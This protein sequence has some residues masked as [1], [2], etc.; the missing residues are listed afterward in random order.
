MESNNGQT[1][2]KITCLWNTVHFIIFLVSGFWH[3]ANWTFIFW[4]LFH[5]ILFIP[6]FIFN[7]NRKYT[8]SIVAENRLLPTPKEFL[9]V[10]ITFI[11]VT[12]GWIF[13]RSETLLDSF[14]YLT[15][16]SLDFNDYSHLSLKILFYI[17]IMI[18]IEWSQRFN[19]RILFF[20]GPKILFRIFVIVIL[21][22]I[23]INFQNDAQQF[24]YFDF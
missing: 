24:I 18:I 22:L 21:F 4:G 3:G 12:I 8:T 1:L 2:N 10:G 20:N 17:F 11:L 5:S 16:L 13:F 9:Q 23:I 14:Y 7:S 6:S 15:S 19:E